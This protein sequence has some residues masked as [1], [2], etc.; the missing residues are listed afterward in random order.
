MVL[1]MLK[2]IEQKKNQLDAK[3]PI[4]A[5]LLANL[6]RWFDLELTYTSNTISRI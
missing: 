1:V 3:R 4:P 2:R 5:N 6:E